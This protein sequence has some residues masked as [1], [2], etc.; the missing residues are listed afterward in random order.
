MLALSTFTRSWILW[1][2]GLYVSWRGLGSSL[3]LNFFFFSCSFT[4]CTSYFCKLYLFHMSSRFTNNISCS[5]NCILLS[6]KPLSCRL[7]LYAFLSCKL[8]S[9]KLYL[10][11]LSCTLWSCKLYPCAFLSNYH[12][13]TCFCALFLQTV[14][15]FFSCSIGPC[16]LWCGCDLRIFSLVWAHLNSFSFR[17][18]E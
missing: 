5:C 18:G 1:V 7:Y 6:C 14:S 10:C 3:R 12:F 11:S 13:A 17:L 2:K 9:C 15:M 4:N 16:I 8:S